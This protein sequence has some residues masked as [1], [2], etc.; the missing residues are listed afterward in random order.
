M[1]DPTVA[2][3]ALI[4]VPA[5]AVLRVDWWGLYLALKMEPLMVEK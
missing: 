1:V 4:S 3:R 5:M 2:W